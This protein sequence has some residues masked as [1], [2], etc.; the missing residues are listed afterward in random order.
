[1]RFAY[2]GMRICASRDSPNMKREFISVYTYSYISAFARECS[3]YM[4]RQRGIKRNRERGGRKRSRR[5]PRALPASRP[6]Y[7][8]RFINFSQRQCQS[9]GGFPAA[10]W[11]SWGPEAPPLSYGLV[12]K[13]KNESKPTDSFS[14]FSHRPR[15]ARGVS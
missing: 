11:G 12:F 1:M 10:G 15:L 3:D 13:F 6:W 2:D 14:L 9:H 7:P 8:L 4:E 5:L